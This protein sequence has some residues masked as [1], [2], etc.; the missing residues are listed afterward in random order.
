MYL[1]IYIHMYT[2]VY[3]YV[4]V[5]MFVRICVCVYI[6][7]YI[8]IDTYI[9]I[10]IYMRC[11]IRQRTG[12]AQECLRTS[13]GRLQNRARCI[14]P[15]PTAT[16]RKASAATGGGGIRIWWPHAHCPE[17]TNKQSPRKRNIPKAVR[18]CGV[19]IERIGD[20]TG[21]GEICI[22]QQHA[23]C[24]DRGLGFGVHPEPYI[25]IYID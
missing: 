18:L 17:K 8:H 24:P 4:Y 20:G 25:E 6:Y 19:C 23:R 5:Y 10:Y 22:R 13:S 7:I 21:G 15:S 11:I 9:Y 14:S 16:E 12:L 2:Y 1:Y 3:T